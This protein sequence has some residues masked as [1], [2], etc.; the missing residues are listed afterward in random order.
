[1]DQLQTRLDA[2]EQPTE[3][4]ERH[5]RPVARRLRCRG[6]MTCGVV[7]LL[8][9]LVISLG[10]EPLAHT[11]VIQCGDVLG[12]GGRFELQD[13]LECGDS[14]LTLRDG[15]TLDLKGHI[16][17]CRELFAGCV[18][19]TGAGA[20]L[21]NGAV[22]GGDH[23]SIV[24]EG[25]GGHTVRD[26]TST[27]VD[28]NVVVRSHHNRLINVMAESANNAAF[29]IS[30]NQNRL[31]DSIARCLNLAFQG[32][33][34]VRGSGNRLLNNFAT[35]T[36]EPSFEIAGNNNVL[37]GNRAIRNDGAGILVTGTGNRLQHNTA[38]ENAVDLQ[39]THGDCAHNT[40]RQNTFRT[41][42]PAC[43][44]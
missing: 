41:S 28:A 35:A 34:F 20:Q 3:T 4:L 39:D 36:L 14:G 25:A 19:L 7:M 33:I 15:A 40:W 8:G 12:P 43:I 38:L 1:M 42:D 22:Q 37:R 17:A 44:Q 31:T 23:E 6:P 26:V 30:G 2:L 21:L 9:V 16:V 10:R 29:I 13:N 32:C 11:D 27:L 18:V 5:A 24:L